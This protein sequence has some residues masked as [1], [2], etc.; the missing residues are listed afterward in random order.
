[1]VEPTHESA[2]Y[3]SI[4][5]REHESSGNGSL[6]DGNSAFHLPLLHPEQEGLV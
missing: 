3:L 4:V 6:S 1:M 2:S 5:G